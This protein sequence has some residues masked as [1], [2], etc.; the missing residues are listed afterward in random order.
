MDWQ[1]YVDQFLLDFPRTCCN[2]QYQFI[3]AHISFL[4]GISLSL[5]FFPPQL[6]LKA[7]LVLA[8]Y[9]GFLLLIMEKERSYFLLFKQAISDFKE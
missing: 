3:N 8:S 7:K 9:V 2:N 4:P 1:S 5:G 6:N